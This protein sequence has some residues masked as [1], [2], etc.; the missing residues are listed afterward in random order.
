[1]VLWVATDGIAASVYAG[2]NEI[3]GSVFMTLL[4]IV[5]LLMIIAMI[6]RIPLEFT[7]ILI[8]P[9]LLT[10][11]AFESDFMS[12]TGVILIYLGIIVGKNL[13]FSY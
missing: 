11:L 9:M 10:F 1:M 6:F 3:T 2:L 13:F 5:I 8:M 4:L 12:V 7:A